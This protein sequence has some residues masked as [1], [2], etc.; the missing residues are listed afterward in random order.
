MDKNELVATVEAMIAAPSCC[1][2]LK[3]AGRAWL[4]A[5][6]T[7]AEKAAGAA[8]L[9]EVKDDVC[10]LEHTIGFFESAAGAKF[11]GAEKARAMAAHARELKASGAKWCDCPACAACVK[12][13]E[14]A[15]LLD[16]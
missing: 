13:M 4:D 7:A 9:A 2:E 5:V 10:T 3:A 6:G 14:N 16:A 1:R 11:F 12:I 8:L 15:G